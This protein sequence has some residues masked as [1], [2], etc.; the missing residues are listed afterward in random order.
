MKRL[1]MLMLMALSLSASAKKMVFVM[2]QT[3]SNAGYD[4]YYGGKY[5]MRT[6]LEKDT[7]YVYV[8]NRIYYSSLNNY[9]IILEPIDDKDWAVSTYDFIIDCNNHT[10]YIG[11]DSTLH[12]YVGHNVLLD[13]DTIYQYHGSRDNMLFGCYTENW[14]LD[15]TYLNTT[16]MIAPE[17]YA[18]IPAVEAWANGESEYYIRRQAAKGYSEFQEIPF[19]QAKYI[20]G[21]Q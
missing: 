4:Q 11:A 5:G 6:F 2:I 19:D 15:N 3:P 13:V 1:L 17:A 18:I 12:V 8:D 10:A 20:F 16:K 14:R 21:L 7:N 9:Y